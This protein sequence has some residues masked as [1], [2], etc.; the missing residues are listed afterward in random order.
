MADR[1]AILDFLGMTDRHIADGERHIADQ[2]RILANLEK[3]GAS[4]I[5]VQ[6][7]QLL[8]AMESSQ[9]LHIKHRDRLK[10][11]LATEQS[12]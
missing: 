2:Q 10:E 9:L 7:R 4:E 6:A 8:V 12:D 1:S 11:Q 5:V 3:R